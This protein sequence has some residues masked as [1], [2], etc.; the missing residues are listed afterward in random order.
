MMISCFRTTRDVYEVTGRVFA[1]GRNAPPPMDFRSLI[2][3]ESAEE[4]IAAVRNGFPYAWWSETPDCKD[5][6][7]ID[8]VRLALTL[9]LEVE[10]PTE[11]A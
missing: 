6:L 1:V 4:A 11:E 3:A 8:G 9:D 2:V 5:R 10:E 7:R